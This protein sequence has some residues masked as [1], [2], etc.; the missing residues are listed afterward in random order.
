MTG[1]VDARPPGVDSPTPRLPG[2]LHLVP[3]TLDLGIPAEPTALTDVLPMATI[4]TAARLTH[5]VVENAKSARAFLKRV[6]EVCPL[7]APLQAHHIVTLPARD[8]RAACG[9]AGGPRVTLLSDLLEPL[10]RG[11]D[12]GLLSEA[13]M[14]GVADPGAELVAA[15]H[16]EGFAVRALVGPSALLLALAASG[17]N[18]QSFAFVGYL[19]VAAA[20]RAARI[21]DLEALSRRTGQTQMFI[22][23]PYRNM[24]MLDALLATL[25][26]S[27]RL[28]LA[29]G[30]T[31]PLGWSRT[32]AVAD[33]RRNRPGL[34]ANVPTVFAL[35]AA[36]G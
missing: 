11:H 24:Q 22:E 33:W 10:R 35:L 28:A 12:L 29:H 19:P 9:N 2:M 8:K 32:C 16:D 26:G 18:G 34:Q 20:A 7:A 13:G 6:G 21:R 17:L 30:L 23:T 15:A 31:T 14:P 36:Q 5:W 1:S 25:A 4:R 3:N 27:T